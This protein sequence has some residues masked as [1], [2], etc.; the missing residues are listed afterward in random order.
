MAQTEHQRYVILVEILVLK[1]DLSRDLAE[2][3]RP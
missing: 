1:L 3:C 2:T